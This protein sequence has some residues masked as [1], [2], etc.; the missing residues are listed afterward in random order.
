MGTGSYVGNRARPPYNP[1][2]AYPA[3]PMEGV[4]VRDPFAQPS[5]V[6]PGY[7]HSTP[8]A[9]QIT[10]SSLGTTT[11]VDSSFYTHHQPTVVY[12]AS[13][14]NEVMTRDPYAQPPSAFSGH[15]HLNLQPPSALPG[16]HHRS[17]NSRHF[18]PSYMGTAANGGGSGHMF[19][20]PT[21]VYS[22]FAAR[23]TPFDP[24]W[25]NDRDPFGSFVAGALPLGDLDWEEGIYDPG[26]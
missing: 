12:P 13:A 14:F 11:H 10:P 3:S 4:M 6:P 8:T 23:E 16:Y 17:S 20:D 5:S 21:T 25:S 24:R 19:N 22:H 2:H 15:H 26:Q 9:R 1:A 18:T 7:L